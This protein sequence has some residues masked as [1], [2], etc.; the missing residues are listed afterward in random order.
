MKPVTMKE[1]RAL[2][3]AIVLYVITVVIIFFATS[4][5]AKRLNPSPVKPITNERNHNL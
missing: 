2:F 5:A 1:Y 3:I 4:F